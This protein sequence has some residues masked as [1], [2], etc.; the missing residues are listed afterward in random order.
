MNMKKLFAGSILYITMIALLSATVQIPAIA[1]TAGNYIANMFGEN[2]SLSIRGAYTHISYTPETSSAAAFVG[3]RYDKSSVFTVDEIPAGVNVSHTSGMCYKNIDASQK[4]V[5]ETAVYASGDA[6]AA[7]NAMWDDSFPQSVLLKIDANG[8]CWYNANGT[9]T[10]YDSRF[11]K[12]SWHKVRISYDTARYRYT[13]YVDGIFLTDTTAIFGSNQASQMWFG[14]DASSSNG[15]VAYD[16][17][18][19]YYGEYVESETPDNSLYSDIHIFKSSE[20]D[21]VAIKTAA[22]TTENH[23]VIIAAYRDG[24]L[25]A[26]DTHKTKSPDDCFVSVPIDTDYSYKAFIWQS[27]NISPLASPLS[28]ENADLSSKPTVGDSVIFNTNFED[29]IPMDAQ[30]NYGNIIEQRTDTDGNK[31]AY[32]ERANTGDFHLSATGIEAI[33]SDYVV[34]E[35]EFKM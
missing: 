9:I 1:D 32:F 16:D 2:A 20:N 30:R 27:D 23:T 13:L 7:I 31:V 15:I 24:V 25:E 10:K 29:C 17:F 6:V 12:N 28:I 21:K 14:V 19:G 5:F 34:Y 35:F 33:D 26:V 11:E 4:Y 18:M 3:G 22:Q 8:N